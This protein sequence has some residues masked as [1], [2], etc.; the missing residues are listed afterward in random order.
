MTAPA[1]ARIMLY[2][3]DTFGLGHLRRCRTLANAFVEDLPG[4]SALIVTGSRIAGAFSFRDEVDFVKIP[5]VVK[6]G[7]GDYEPVSP[8]LDIT[9]TLDLR[10]ALLRET[11]ER[12]APDIF[13]V[14]KEPMGLRGEVESTLVAMR[15]AGCKTVLGLRDVMDSPQQLAEEWQGTG[16]IDKIASLFD[17]V[18]IYGPEGFWDPLKAMVLPDHLRSRIRYTGFL[19][20]EAASDIFVDRHALPEHFTLVTAGGG[21]DG[22]DIMTS[23]LT[24]C[25]HDRTFD[26]PLVLVPGPFMAAQDRAELHA[27]ADHL[28]HVQ[29]IDFEEELE[30]IVARADAVVGMCGYNTFCEI[31]SFDKPAL[32]IPRTTPREEQLIRA[33]EA[34]KRGAC[35]MLLPEDARDPEKMMAAL[36]NLLAASPPSSAKAPLALNGLET[37]S[38]RVA[39]LL[40]CHDGGDP[41]P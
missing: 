29:I 2:S 20:R 26:H 7:A 33:G 10:E 21:G 22:G 23:V 9:E 8:H 17:E 25:E 34:E 30:A 38:A 39:T 4:T 3:H 37:V 15:M 40:Q 31:L 28:T 13:I 12:F 18:W 1:N 32:F 41:A 16:M 27:R 14:D 36:R 11:A 5:S 35:S 19:R 6:R 24:A